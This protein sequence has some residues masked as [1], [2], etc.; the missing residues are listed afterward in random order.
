MSAA[1]YH[2]IFL[3][4]GSHKRRILDHFSSF[5][6]PMNNTIKILQTLG[7]PFRK[8]VVVALAAA[9]RTLSFTELMKEVLREIT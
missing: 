6:N 7:T 4:V 2:Q 1:E 8:S 5:Q 9:H 3:A